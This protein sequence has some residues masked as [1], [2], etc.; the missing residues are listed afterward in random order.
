MGRTA[1]D[2]N[3]VCEL[4]ATSQVKRN[5]G[6]VI[7][8]GKRDCLLNRKRDVVG[9]ARKRSE[10]PR[11]RWI[12]IVPGS[13]K[14]STKGAVSRLQIY[15][16]AGGAGLPATG[17]LPTEKFTGVAVDGQSQ[18]GATIAA[19][20]DAAQVRRLTHIGSLSYQW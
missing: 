12:N 6:R 14:T 13:L 20:P 19:G 18:R 9:T 2:E 17:Q 10:M 3:P 15:G 1:A 11:F 5:C 16:T 7:A 4:A 8:R